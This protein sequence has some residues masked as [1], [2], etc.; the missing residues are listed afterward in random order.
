MEKISLER[1]AGIVEKDESLKARLAASP[2]PGKALETMKRLA[3]EA[4]YELDLPVMLTKLS[5]DD[6]K[7]VMGGANPF[8]PMNDGELNPYSWFVTFLRR[9]MGW[10][11]GEEEE[12]R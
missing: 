2:D 12:K 3:A 8:I 11:R 7:G 5:D 10:R 1:F 4:G 6:V 9:L